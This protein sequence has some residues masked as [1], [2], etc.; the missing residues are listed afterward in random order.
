MTARLHEYIFKNS[1]RLR[2]Q[3]MNYITCELYLNK[4]IILKKFK[5]KRRNLKLLGTIWDPGDEEIS[6][7]PRE[8]KNRKSP[9]SHVLRCETL[10]STFSHNPEVNSVFPGLTE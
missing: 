7:V 9:F 3:W 6:K 1:L 10:S 2:F 4:A 8:K 5:W